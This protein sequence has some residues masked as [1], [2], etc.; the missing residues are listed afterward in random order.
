M[1]WCSPPREGGCH[2]G[3]SDG[4][5]H[6]WWP[7]TAWAAA[8]PFRH[9]RPDWCSTRSARAP[10]SPRRSGG[11]WPT[12]R[13]PAPAHT[14]TP[15]CT[16]KVFWMVDARPSRVVRPGVGGAEKRGMTIWLVTGGCGFIG[17]HLCAALVAA[18]RRARARV[19]SWTTCPRAGG[20]TSPP[21]PS[22]WSEM[23][24][25][26]SCW[27][28]LWKASPAASTSPPSPQWSAACA[29]G[30]KRTE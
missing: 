27:R 13:P 8:R 17:S 23:W 25:T 6:R 24:A 30:G 4:L 15:M 20:R 5:R 18:G 16:N 21:A 28:A 2:G 10:R 12:R 26:R 1:R 3:G 11:C 22:C 7:G 19:R 9:S 14:H 29:N